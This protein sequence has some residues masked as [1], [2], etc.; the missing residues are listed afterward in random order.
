MKTQINNLVRGN[1]FRAGTNY[2]TRIDLVQK[3]S[4]ENPEFLIVKLRGKEFTL[5]AN[6]SVSRKSVSYSGE[7]DLDIYKS[8][9]GDF[10]LPVSEPKAYLMIQPDLT[11]QLTTNSKKSFYNYIEESEIEIL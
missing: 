8:F 11:V 2:S 6:W 9:I 5:K 10:G 4:A 7:I 1:Q 3:V